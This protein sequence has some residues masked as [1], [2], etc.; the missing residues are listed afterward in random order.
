M[1]TTTSKLLI[2]RSKTLQN[3]MRNKENSV[4]PRFVTPPVF[5]FSWIILILLVGAGIAVWSGQIPSYIAGS[6]IILA[7]S[8]T[9]NQGDG[10]TAAI[11]L[12]GSTSIYIR[13]GLPVQLQIGQTG[14]Q[15]HRTID[16]VNQNLLSPGAVHQQYGFTVTDPSL[17]VTVKLGSTIPEY[18]YSGS[19]V[20]AQIRIG[21]QNLLALFPVVNNL[22]KGQ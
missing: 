4:L 22:L 1:A 11:L 16:I 10:A 7:A 13:P 2:F 12:P 19:P 20:H 6:G 14:P 15:V 21:S 9:D 3:Y 5:A 17:V 8:S 18:L